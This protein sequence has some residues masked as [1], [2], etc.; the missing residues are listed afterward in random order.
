MEHDIQRPNHHRRPKESNP[1]RRKDPA[2][3]SQEV[4]DYVVAS[5]TVGIDGCRNAV[6]AYY[7][8]HWYAQP[9]SLRHDRQDVA[10]SN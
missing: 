2:K 9:E 5:P 7:E 6:T 10:D 8:E 4:G 1:V 3:A